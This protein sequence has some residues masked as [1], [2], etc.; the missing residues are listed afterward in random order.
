MFLK[1]VPRH[2]AA[3]SNPNFPNIFVSFR[4]FQTPVRPRELTRLFLPPA[5]TPDSKI[6]DIITNAVLTAKF[7]AQLTVLIK[8]HKILSL[9]VVLLRNFF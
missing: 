2:T 1:F 7:K 6:H 9:L 8:C 3:Q 4:R 5:L